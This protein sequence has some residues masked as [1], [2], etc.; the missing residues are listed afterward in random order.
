MPV[1]TRPHASAPLEA[2]NA[3]GWITNEYTVTLSL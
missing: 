3:D 1:G 2:E